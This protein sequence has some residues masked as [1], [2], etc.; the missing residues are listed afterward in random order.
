MQL[1]LQQG[2]QGRQA[3]RDFPP[4]H[5]IAGQFGVVVP[6]AFEGKQLASEGQ[7]RSRPLRKPDEQVPFSAPARRRAAKLL[8]VVFALPVRGNR[9]QESARGTA[10]RPGSQR[11]LAELADRND[12]DVKPTQCARFV[13][14]AL[15]KHGLEPRQRL[16]LLEIDLPCILEL[17][18]DRCVNVEVAAGEDGVCVEEFLED[19]ERPGIQLAEGLLD[20]RSRRVREAGSQELCAGD[21]AGTLAEQVDDR[22]GLEQLDVKGIAADA[23]AALKRIR[24]QRPAVPVGRSQDRWLEVGA[25]IVPE[26]GPDRTT[27]RPRRG[28]ESPASH[29][30]PLN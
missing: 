8:G 9:Q 29:G 15:G 25:Q 11:N 19:C 24:R 23:L 14:V 27:R 21:E 12:V 30:A 2:L 3:R 18:A 6:D 28:G 7:D 4:G 20:R 17:G 5:V 16:Q 26:D 13:V 10:G 22:D 1:G